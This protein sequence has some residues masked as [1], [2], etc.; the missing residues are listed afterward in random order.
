MLVYVQW[1]R[2]LQPSEYG[3]LKFQNLG[4]FEVINVSAICR[5]VGFLKMPN[6]ENYIIDRE[7]QIRF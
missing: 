5:S 4:T 3:P 1:V 6:N 7:N 2:N